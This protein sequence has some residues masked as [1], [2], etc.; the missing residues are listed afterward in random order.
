[1]ANLNPRSASLMLSHIPPMFVYIVLW[2]EQN[3]DALLSMLFD[4]FREG[5]MAMVYGYMF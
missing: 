1:M 5:S 2:P 4:S 3:R